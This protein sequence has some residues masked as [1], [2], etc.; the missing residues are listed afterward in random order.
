MTETFNKSAVGSP[1]AEEVH[2]IADIEQGK[3]HKKKQLVIPRVFLYEASFICLH[4]FEEIRYE[5][6]YRWISISRYNGKNFWKVLHGN[7]FRI[8]GP[9]Q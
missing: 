2:C 3:V 9:E 1:E 5:K 7:S 6:I 4:Q 8:V